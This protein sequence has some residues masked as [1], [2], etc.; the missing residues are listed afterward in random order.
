MAGIIENYLNVILKY[1]QFSGRSRRREYW[2]F[3]LTNFVIGIVLGILGKLPVIG[4]IFR[5]VIA[6]LFSLAII[7]PS[8][9]VAVRRLQDQNKEWPW[10]FVI[11]IPLVGGI[12]FLIMMATEGTRGEN[13]YGP[14]P[15]A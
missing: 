6:G 2:M 12:W 1:A 13:N 15:K 11:F 3:F 14:D 5:V 4:F 7:V 10:I 9:A 8:I